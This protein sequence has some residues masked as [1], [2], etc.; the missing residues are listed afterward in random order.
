MESDG[1]NIY[2]ITKNTL[3]DNHSELMADGRILYARWEYVDRNFGDAHGI[4]TVNPDGTNQAVY[5]G[6]NTAV[7]GAVFNAH[8]IPGTQ[9]ILCILGPHHDRLWGAMAIK[10]LPR[11]M[12]ITPRRD[13]QS[14]QG[15]FF[16][17][18]VYKGTHTQGIKR[19]TVAQPG[20]TTGC[21][22]CH[23]HRKRKQ[24]VFKK[25]SRPSHWLS[26]FKFHT[27][28]FRADRLPPAWVRISQWWQR[29]YRTP[30]CTKGGL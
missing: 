17:A 8:E 23:D 9:Q 1:A 15:F 27:S 4:W 16:V 30:C 2:Q 22:G 12:N 29:N 26:A 21:V 11:P 28:Y 6:N 13:F 5:W 20:E 10:P 3:F 19:G 14:Q 18:D 7:P 25:G 24:V